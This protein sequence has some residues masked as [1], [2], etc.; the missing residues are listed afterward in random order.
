MKANVG[1]RTYESNSW[2]G[3][4]SLAMAAAG[5]KTTAYDRIQAASALEDGH[6][7]VIGGVLIKPEGARE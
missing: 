2:N 3:V 5:V 1:H 7:T 6:S 4:V